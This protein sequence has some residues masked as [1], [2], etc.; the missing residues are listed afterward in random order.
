M[1]KAEIF[2]PDRLNFNNIKVR[3]VPIKQGGI[4]M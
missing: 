2:L 3:T 4:Y 1:E